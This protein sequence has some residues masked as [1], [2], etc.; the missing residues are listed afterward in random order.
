MTLIFITTITKINTNFSF[1]Y[2]KCFR[3]DGKSLI[4]AG[5]TH[6]HLLLPSA[7]KLCYTPQYPILTYDL[8]VTQV[9]PA[10]QYRCCNQHKNHFMMTTTIGSNAISLNIVHNRDSTSAFFPLL[11]ILFRIKQFQCKFSVP[12]NIQLL[13]LVSFPPSIIHKECHVSWTR[14]AKPSSFGNISFLH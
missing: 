8:T 9:D 4:Y 12:S 6:L 13:P 11:L 3:D 1:I 14:C 7:A 5:S 2:I 10:H